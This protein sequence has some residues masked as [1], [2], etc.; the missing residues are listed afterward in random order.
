MVPAAVAQ[1]GSGAGAGQ[2]DSLAEDGVDML[3]E[4]DDATAGERQVF[5]AAEVGAGSEV[6]QVSFL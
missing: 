1:A 6:E 2:L 4:T 3:V 5:V